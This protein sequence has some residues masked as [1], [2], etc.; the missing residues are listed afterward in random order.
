MNTIFV[1]PP[2][3]KAGKPK[4][5]TSGGGASIWPEGLGQSLS[6]RAPRSWGQGLPAAPRFLLSGEPP[7]PLQGLSQPGTSTCE[8][9]FV[10]R[11]NKLKFSFKPLVSGEPCAHLSENRSVLGAQPHPTLNAGLGRPASLCTEPSP[12]TPALGLRLTS[13][14]VHLCGP[15]GRREP[16]AGVNSGSFCW[17]LEGTGGSGL[18]AQAALQGRRAQAVS[19]GHQDACKEVSGP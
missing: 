8:V 4:P 1:W 19:H 14:T 12:P 18:S 6:R 7:S 9:P 17:G 13:H 15:G 10:R 11:Q 5:G 3:P 16:C 2:A